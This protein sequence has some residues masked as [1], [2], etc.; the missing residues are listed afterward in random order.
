MIRLLNWAISATLRLSL[1][2]SVTAKRSCRLRVAQP[3][4]SQTI[5]DLETELG[6]K[7]L[8]RIKR[9]VQLTAAGTVG[10]RKAEEILRRVTE[11]KTLRLKTFTAAKVVRSGSNQCRGGCE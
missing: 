6:V 9:S 11:G 3:A 10:L 1:N 5:R 4:I 2:T 8:F 7:F